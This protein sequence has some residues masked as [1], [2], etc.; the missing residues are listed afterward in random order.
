MGLGRAEK[1][2]EIVGAFGSS[3]IVCRFFRACR[4][5]ESRG[6]RMVGQLFCAT[7]GHEGRKSL[8]W[9]RKK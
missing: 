9:N 7:R 3:G 4:L 1:E 2:R 6:I 5:P 8:G